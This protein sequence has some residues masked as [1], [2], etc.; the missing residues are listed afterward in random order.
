MLQGMVFCWG[1]ISRR[2]YFNCCSGCALLVLTGR[3]QQ[4]KDYDSV[5]GGRFR[6][7]HFH[8]AAHQQQYISR[9]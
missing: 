2:T 5:S 6:A 7:I 4:V 8:P 3:R 9:L 1:A